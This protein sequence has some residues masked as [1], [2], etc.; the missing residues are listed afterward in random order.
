[1]L[2]TTLTLLSLTLLVGCGDAEAP[3]VDKTQVISSDPVEQV[4]FNTE[5]L[6]TVEFQVP[7]MHCEV[8]C[9]PKVRETLAKQ[10]GVKDV[11]VD[12]ETK[13]A[14]VAVEGG[15]FDPAK[16]IEALEMEDF[17]DVELKVDAS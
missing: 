5:G 14:V 16:A 12:L 11:S 2:R 3:A 13:T 6:P 9:V 10:P 1:M 4:A 17:T 15:E 8:M 7:S